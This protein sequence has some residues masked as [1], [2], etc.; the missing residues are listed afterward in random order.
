M[1]RSGGDRRQRS[2][3][4]VL[5]GSNRGPNGNEGE[6]PSDCVT[7]FHSP[8]MTEGGMLRHCAH[9][10]PENSSSLLLLRQL[11]L[12]TVMGKVTACE[13]RCVGGSAENRDGWVR[14]SNRPVGRKG[15]GWASGHVLRSSTAGYRWLFAASFQR[16]NIKLPAGIHDLELRLWTKVLRRKRSFDLGAGESGQ[17]AV[18]GYGSTAQT[19]KPN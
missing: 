16:I 11:L 19:P 18:S 3:K 5:R 13:R 6:H 7:C 1:P 2:C 12:K 10:H 9:S 15:V 17:Q 14:R 8:C 4:T